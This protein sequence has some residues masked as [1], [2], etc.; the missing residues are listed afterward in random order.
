[1]KVGS[2]SYIG[3]RVLERP[4]KTS[5][6]VYSRFRVLK[7]SGSKVIESADVVQGH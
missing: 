6:G 5:F 7:F 1:M 4:E 2:T 3:G